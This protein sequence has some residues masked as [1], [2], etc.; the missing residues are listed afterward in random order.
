MEYFEDGKIKLMHEYPKCAN[1]SNYIRTHFY[2]N[3]QKSSYGYFI[4][5]LK[6]GVFKTWFENGQLS[7]IWETEKGKSIGKA[8]CFRE[9]GTLEREA[10]AYGEA[11]KGY[12]KFYYEDEKLESEGETLNDSTKIGKWIEYYK[13][14]KPEYIWNYELGKRNGISSTYYENGNLESIL[15]F[16][17]DSL[18]TTKVKFDTLGNVTL[19]EQEK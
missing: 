6:S 3:G 5:N 7:A 13:N 4:N 19:G 10:I 15:V 14:G 18:K 8:K 12:F 17:N 9:D 11:F 16:D 2:S 1:K